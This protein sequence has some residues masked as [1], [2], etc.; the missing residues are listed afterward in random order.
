MDPMNDIKNLIDEDNLDRFADGTT[1]I[2]HSKDIYSL[3]RETSSV[4]IALDNFLPQM[5]GQVV[6]L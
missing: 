6:A 1:I 5:H 4:L 2:L 3:I